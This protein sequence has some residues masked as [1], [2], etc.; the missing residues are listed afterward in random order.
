MW[1]F[2]SHMPT[3]V[4]E[5]PVDVFVFMAVYF[6]LAVSILIPVAKE[7]HDASR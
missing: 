2:Y 4:Y 6:V 7:I 1:V 5:P 3:A